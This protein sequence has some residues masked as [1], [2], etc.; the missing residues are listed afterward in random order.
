M[1]IEQKR[2]GYLVGQIILSAVICAPLPLQSAQ[3][4]PWSKF[5]SNAVSSHTTKI[6][7][8]IES[9]QA[10]GIS[11]TIY[12]FQRCWGIFSYLG[13]SLEQANPDLSE[14]LLSRASKSLELGARFSSGYENLTGQKQ[15]VEAYERGLQSMLKQYLDWANEN[16][17][18][19][20]QNTDSKMQGDLRSCNEFLAQ[21]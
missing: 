20:G 8:I 15:S 11:E 17:V 19:S 10:D 13:V 7:N 2:Q 5:F 18:S 12:V 6:V 9:N 21:L 14:L 16:Y 3:G 1:A 4:E